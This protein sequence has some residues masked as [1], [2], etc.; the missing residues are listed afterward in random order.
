M[1][2]FWIL[3][4]QKWTRARRAK[5]RN[6]Q[7]SRASARWRALSSKIEHAR[8][9]ARDHVLRNVIENLHF[10]YGRSI[11]HYGLLTNNIRALSKT[12]LRWVQVMHFLAV[13]EPVLTRSKTNRNIFREFWKRFCLKMIVLSEYS[14]LI[15]ASFLK[16]QCTSLFL[17]YNPI[18]VP[19]GHDFLLT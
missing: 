15:F 14:S 4:Y 13:Y 12:F 2:Y 11:I 3:H 1:K 5:L 7:T 18:G 10:F 17:P 9:K 6:A 19:Y 8:V 16:S